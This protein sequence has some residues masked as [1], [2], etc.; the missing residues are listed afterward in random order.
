MADAH[1]HSTTPSRSGWSIRTRL[2]AGFGVV[3]VLFL[4]MAAITYRRIAEIRRHEVA[5][6]TDSI[7]GLIKSSAIRAGW[8][9]DL[10]YVQQALLQ[11]NAAD[12]QRLIA[13][14]E[15]HRDELDAAIAQYEATIFTSAD[16][17]LFDAFKYAR[18]TFDR[19]LEEILRSAADP[20]RLEQA[21]QQ[22]AAQ[23]VPA[24]DRGTAALQAVQTHNETSARGSLQQ[25]ERE[26]EI[27]EAILMWSLAAAL[28]IT[29]I[30]GF[31]LARSITGPLQQINAVVDRVTRGD[32]TRRVGL[33]RR[34]ELGQLGDGFDRMVDELTGLVVQV[35]S[36]GSRV[37]AA[38]TNIATTARQQQATVNEIAATTTE[39]GATSREI[40][41]TSRE[42]VRTMTQVSQVADQSAALGTQGQTGLTRMEE[43]IHHVMEAAGTVNAKLAILNEKAADISQVIVTITK[44]ADQ[45][46]LLSLNAAIEAEK[47]G[48]YGR[49]FAV[50]A[51]EIRRLADQ[52]AVSTSD[53]EQMVKSMQ[54]SVAAG[55][56]SMDK[57]SD[58]VRRGMDAV[59]QVS[60]Q[61][62]Q[63]IHE[64]QA[65]APRFES[66]SEGMQAQA[67]G[68]E[69]INEALA[70][71]TEASQQTVESLRLSSGAIDDLNSVSMG[72]KTD[73]ARFSL[74]SA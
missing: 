1:S 30:C 8:V 33:A 72:L 21:R 40:A 31:L 69:Q 11:P 6:E 73:I 56:M 9:D 67:T 57:F 18:T 23:L 26:T 15:S 27:A 53:I 51:T 66:V 60:A 46:N 29:S 28:I 68:A 55:V 65:L 12:R 10:G 19:Q 5:I 24:Y 34:D 70:Q 7:A 36:S 71:L 74:R 3:L 59:Q 61:L 13:T 25:I 58:E 50:V 39:V 48:D 17:Q 42:L 38:V 35:Q 54:S 32:F 37:A 16:R 64:V 52:T 4:V 62:S 44:V 22:F 2:I 14:I 45:T 49:G 20:L 41:A 43:I 63:V 47:A